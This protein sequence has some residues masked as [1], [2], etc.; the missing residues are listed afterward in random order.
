MNVNKKQGFTLVELLVVI[1]ILGILSAALFP[2]IGNAVLK[3]NMTAVG[4]RGKDIFVAIIGAN[5]EREPLGLGNVWPKTKLETGAAGGADAD[6]AEQTFSTSSK[7]FEELMDSENFGKAEW[8]PY[9]NGIDFSKLAGA[10]VPAKPDAGGTLNKA[11]NMW[12][13]AADVRDEMEDIIPILVTRN[14]K[15]DETILKKKVSNPS[16]TR[17][18]KWYMETADR[19]APFSNKG[20]VMVRKGGAVFTLSSRYINEF[21]VYQGQSFDTTLGGNEGIKYLIP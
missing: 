15:E 16:K 1:G 2:A 8:A 12:T 4:T 13:I 9:V 14:V 21:T 20:F 11:N 19:K 5:T 10:G 17:V 18:D 7:Y 6:I 3:A